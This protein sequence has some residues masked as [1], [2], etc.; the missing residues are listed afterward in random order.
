M[1]PVTLEPG[2]YEG[3]VPE[4]GWSRRNSK[5]GLLVDEDEDE[6]RKPMFGVALSF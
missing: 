6:D 2:V 4:K 5:D 1:V 3:S